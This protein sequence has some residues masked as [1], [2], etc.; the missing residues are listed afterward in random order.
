M[1]ALTGCSSMT[2]TREPPLTKALGYNVWDWKGWTLVGINETA[3]DIEVK[4]LDTWRV[5]IDVVNKPALE[6]REQVINLW[7]M[8]AT[9]G[10]MGGIPL[11]LRAVPKGYKKEEG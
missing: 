11:A 7:S 2:P 10:A 9:G 5:M 3:Y 1:M 6:A 4:K 8:V